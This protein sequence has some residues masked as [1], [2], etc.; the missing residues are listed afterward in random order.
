MKAPFTP[1]QFFSVFEK[2][3]LAVFPAQ[4]ILLLMGVAVLYLL[5]SG[6][7]LRDRLIPVFMAGLW[8]WSG[9]VYHWMFFSESNK[10]A[11]A[12]GGLFIVQGVLF[13]WMAFRL[14][15]LSFNVKMKPKEL[16]GYFLV[17]FGLFM[18]PMIGYRLG[19]PI[20]RSISLG[21]PCPTTITTFGLLMLTNGKFPKYLLIIPG[22]WAL[23]G[24]SAALKFGVYQ[25][26]VLLLSALIAGFYRFRQKEQGHSHVIS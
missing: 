12:F 7:A 13:L 14:E 11:F 1:E 6:S 19:A 3:N 26:I 4:I 20:N 18:Y 24:F 2:Y 10:A 16:I 9:L 21:L 25:D 23:L 5:H 17:F 8:L 15:P 22:L